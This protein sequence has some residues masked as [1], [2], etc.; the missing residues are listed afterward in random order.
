M[1]AL[2]CKS[3]TAQHMWPERQEEEATQTP[4]GQGGP[5]SAQE[6]RAPTLV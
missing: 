6:W 2:S 4:G 3:A 5:R 1:Y